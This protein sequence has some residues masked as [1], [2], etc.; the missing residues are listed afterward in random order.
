[1]NDNPLITHT[2]S[3]PASTFSGQDSLAPLGPADRFQSS[4]IRNKTLFALGILLIKLCL[5]RP[6]EDIRA[7]W[8]HSTGADPT[9]A[10]TIVDD[11]EIANL[12]ADSIYL[13]AGDSYGYAVLRC[14]RCEFAGRD[15]TKSFDFEQFRKHFFNGVVAPIQATFSMLPATSA[16]V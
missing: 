11:Y 5:N 15:V 2:F 13:E 12:Q 8:L 3:A 4:Q 10:S 7:E 14:L 9:S 6:F 16:M 1:M